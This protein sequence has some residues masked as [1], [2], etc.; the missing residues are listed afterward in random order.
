[1]RPVQKAFGVDA[2]VKNPETNDHGVSE[3]PR[4][5]NNDIY[6]WV[7]LLRPNDPNMPA[8]PW[9][10]IVASREMKAS[11]PREIF[12]KRLMECLETLGMNSPLPADVEK[13][14]FDKAIEDRQMQAAYEAFNKLLESDRFNKMQHFVQQEL[15]RLE[16]CFAFLNKP[17]SL[18]VPPEMSEWESLWIGNLK[19]LTNTI[20]GQLYSAKES[21]EFMQEF[22]RMGRTDVVSYLLSGAHW[23][24]AEAIKGRKPRMSAYKL[25]VAYAHASELSHYSGSAADGDPVEA[26]KNRICRVKRSP[27]KTSMLSLLLY[28]FVKM[29]SMRVNESE[30]GG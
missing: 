9:D 4:I 19:Y 10:F 8:E 2:E 15:K 7:C 26:M 14:L 16:K 13:V 6:H 5:T 21:L 12:T 17:R 25:L 24:I 22:L 30:T 1:V 28:Q 27:T 11:M 18:A 20:M 23:K 29:P 3:K